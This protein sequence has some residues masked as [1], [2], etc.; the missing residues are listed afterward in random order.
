MGGNGGQGGLKQGSKGYSRVLGKGQGG[1]KQETD[2][3]K[4]PTNFSSEAPCL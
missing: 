2:Q 3:R 4:E 1:K